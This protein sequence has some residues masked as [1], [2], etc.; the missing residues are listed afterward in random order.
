MPVYNAEKF[1]AE[2]IESVLNQ[3]FHDFELLIINDG[4]TDG[5]RE[6][7]QSYKDERVRLVDNETN[8]RLIATLN[9]GIELAN[10]RY[11]ARMDADDVCL[12]HRL[13]KQVALMDAHPEVGLCG[14]YLA[15][16]G[17]ESDYEVGFA[18][19]HD[20]IKFRL[21]FDTHFPHPAAII[22]KSVLTQHHLHFEIEYIHAEDFEMWNRMAE[23]CKLAVIPEVLVMKRSHG[24]QISSL[25]SETQDKISRK[26]REELIEKLGVR[27]G[28]AEM[29]VYEDFLKGKLPKEKG[30][31]G[32]LLD[33]FEKLV[34]ANNAGKRY[35]PDLFNNYFAE[36]YWQLCAA[37]THLGL[38]IFRKYRNSVFNGDKMVKESSQGRFFI[39]SLIRYSGN[40]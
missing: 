9:K 26:I 13:E 4:S 6:I 20:E 7:I 27:V 22:R 15:T 28:N 40:G 21:F 29:N 16:I 8:L 14:S 25:H 19:G 39:K 32:L 17:L 18:T 10:G 2:A 34:I 23:V 24:E 11:I 35:K 12:P 31:V 36:K 38:W 3:T 1:L 30:S 5:S 33:L 37:S